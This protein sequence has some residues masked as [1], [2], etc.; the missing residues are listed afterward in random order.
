MSEGAYELVRVPLIE[1][2][3]EVRFHGDARV[4]AIRGNFQEAIV[5][6]FPLL[7]VPEVTL[8]ESPALVPYR[9][10]NQDGTRTVA[11]A[12][13]S[14][15]YLTKQYPGWATFQRDFLGYWGEFTSRAQP[16]GIGRVGMRFVNQ[17]DGELY[18]HL[19]L[20]GAPEYLAPLRNATCDFLRSA[21]NYDNGQVG[22]LINV[23][24]PQ[25]ESALVL[26]YDAYAQNATLETLEATLEELHSRIEAE[27]QLALRDEYARTLSSPKAG[28]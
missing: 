28:G 16:R 27:F 22:L 3:I 8:G 4:D 5:E 12:I 15:A 17:F 1:A 24:K 13:N 10:Q 2:T 6:E 19:D 23:H 26:D 18:E 25:N 20:D 7:F 14:L 9:F 11:L 21:T